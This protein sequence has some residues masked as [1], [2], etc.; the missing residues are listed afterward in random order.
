MHLDQAKAYMDEAFTMVV[1]SD[2][3]GA[4]EK[5]AMERHIV[6]GLKA[7]AEFQIR[8]RKATQTMLRDAAAGILEA[9]ED[10][11]KVDTVK[12]E[13]SIKFAEKWIGYFSGV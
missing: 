4:K 2:T 5:M 10:L 9:L 3:V 7:K 13:Q 8:G 12:Y 11:E 6:R 1:H